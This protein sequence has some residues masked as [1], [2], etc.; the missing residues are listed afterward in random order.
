MSSFPFEL[1]EA[2]PFVIKR[3]TAGSYVKGKWT[4]ATPTDVNAEG[5]IYE[6]VKRNGLTFLPESASTTRV[7][8]IF[9]NTQLYSLQEQPVRHDADEITWLGEKYR[10]LKVARWNV[11]KFNGYDAYAML[12]DSEL[13]PHA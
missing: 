7:I 4:K 3:F 2:T 6:L 12:I 8:R 9:T 5:V 1:V 11:N 13:T 10:V